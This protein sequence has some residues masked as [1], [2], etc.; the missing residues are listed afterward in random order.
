MIIGFAG[1]AASGK[2]TAARHLAPLLEGEAQIIPMAMVLRDEVDAFLRAI[3]AEEHVP[4]VYGCQE[5]KLRVF[6][7]DEAKALQQCPQWA[8]FVAEHGDIQDRAGQSA[9]TVRRILQ[10]WGTEYRRA[11]DPDYWTKAWA[12]K[13][14]GYDLEKV[15]ILVDDVRFMNELRTLRELGAKMVKIDR[16]GFAAGGNHASE[17][18]LDDYHDWCL[19]LRN[20]GTL[21]E[22]KQKVEDLLD[23]FANEQV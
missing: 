14:S 20:T 16:P 9:V 11:Q 12:R 18:S 8:G 15:H 13:V 2:T 19:I 3:G 23:L 10:W 17:T 22:F 7:I 1:K 6:Y 21:D 5:D 4:L